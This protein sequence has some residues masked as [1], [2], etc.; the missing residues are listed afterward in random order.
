MDK[1]DTYTIQE[2]ES[3]KK[4]YTLLYEQY[5]GSWKELLDRV[6]QKLEEKKQKVHS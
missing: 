5:G 3:E 2:L 6:N 4:K 1:L